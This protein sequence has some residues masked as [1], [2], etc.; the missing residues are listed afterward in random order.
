MSKKFW[1]L[2]NTGKLELAENVESYKENL[3]RYSGY[4]DKESTDSKVLTAFRD[5]N[6]YLPIGLDEILKTLRLKGISRCN[7]GSN[8]RKASSKLEDKSKGIH[9]T[10]NAGI[11]C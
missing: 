6:E 4:V 5:R 8:L 9:K 11:D 2:L 10:A 3:Q 7:K 1:Q